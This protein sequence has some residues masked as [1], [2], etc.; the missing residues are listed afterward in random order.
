LIAHIGGAGHRHVLRV[1]ARTERGERH[2]NEDF[3]GLADIGARG[4]CCALSD[5]AG[6]HGN[7]A[8][9]AALT[10]DS[11]LEAW[12]VNPLFAPVGLASLI[13][14]A[15]QAV[16]TQQPTAVSRKHMTATVVLLCIEP[17][18]GRALWAHWGDS[19]LYW[20]RGGVVC[21][22]T[23][24]HSVVQQL[25][26]AGLYKDDDVRQLP[27]RNV[28]VGAVG[29]DSQ[30]PPTVLPQPVDVHSGDAFLLC[31]D[32]LWENL[33]EPAMEAALKDCPNPSVWLDRMTQS[34]LALG[35]PNQDNCSALAVWVSPG[36]DEGATEGPAPSTR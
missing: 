16:S 26:Q 2:A 8:L 35:K 13:S 36:H 11:V 27:N 29:A 18:S 3:M 17:V 28:L 32:G 4:F 30:V 31:S 12:R 23:Q 5:G 9:A 10:V 34:V 22:I 19:R 1:A 7:G 20:F 14:M 6:G 21:S 24:D 25:R 15:E 33:D